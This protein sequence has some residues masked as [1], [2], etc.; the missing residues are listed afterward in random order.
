[1]DLLCRRDRALY[2][3]ARPCPPFMGNFRVDLQVGSTA[4][5]VPRARMNFFIC[6]QLKCSKNWRLDGGEIVYRLRKKNYDQL[7]RDSYLPHFLVLYTLP[8]ARSSWLTHYPEH[9]RFARGAYFL[10]LR[11]RSPRTGSSDV[12]VRIPVTNRLTAKTLAQLYMQ[13]TRRHAVPRGGA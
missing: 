8:S 13:E 6:L 9:D 11:G 1:M 5:I 3:F 2:P 12:V 7:I 10:D 4:G